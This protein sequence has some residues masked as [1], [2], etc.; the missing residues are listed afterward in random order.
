MGGEDFLSA[1]GSIANALFLIASVYIYVALLRQ[2]NRR[3]RD[4][5]DT[6]RGFGAAEVAL[7]VFLIAVFAFSSLGASSAQIVRLRTLD[8]ILNA[9]V[10]IGMVLFVAAFLK[11]RRFN[12]S[13]LTGLARLSFTRAFLTG[14]VLLIFAYPLIIFAEWLTARCLGPAR[15]ARASSNY[16]AARNQWS[17]ASSSFYW[18][19]RSPLW[20]RNSFS[21][22][23]FTG[24]CGVISVVALDSSFRRFYLLLFT[25]TFRLSRPSL[26]SGSVL[27]WPTS[28]AD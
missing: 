11:L 16:S 19:L 17:N 13:E 10:A 14:L 21:V 5:I 24:S 6:D 4:P 1:V 23:F 27:L 15:V 3:D 26:L 12:L 18:R 28:G 7:A 9:V 25:C 22:S 2:I 20:P 8:L